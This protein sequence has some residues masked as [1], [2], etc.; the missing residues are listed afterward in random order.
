MVDF[1]LKQKCTE[2]KCLDYPK[3]QSYHVY[4]YSV[5]GCGRCMKN[6]NLQNWLFVQEEYDIKNLFIYWKYHT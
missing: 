6:I 4:S 3:S 1:I 5:I 2:M